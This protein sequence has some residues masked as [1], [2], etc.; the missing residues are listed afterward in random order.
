MAF[1]IYIP[2]NKAQVSPHAKWTFVG[3]K[4]VCILDIISGCAPCRLRGCKNGPT[5]F[6]GRIS[7]KA[8]KPGLVS[9]LYLSMFF[10][11]VGV[12]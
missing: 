6:P 2:M 8:T 7:Y 5:P 3:D 11:C 10:Y 1:K 4:I 12:Y 9:V